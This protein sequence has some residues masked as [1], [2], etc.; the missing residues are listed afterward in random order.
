MNARDRIRQKTTEAAALSGKAMAIS[1]G[2]DSRSVELSVAEA[3][4][5]RDDDESCGFK[6]ALSL[7]CGSGSESS[8]TPIK[9]S[10]YDAGETICPCNE[11]GPAATMSTSTMAP[12][13]DGGPWATTACMYGE[14]PMT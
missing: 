4:A 3:A 7:G 13:S 10:F 11:F 8:C 14:R 12:M 1:A 9:P 2:L 6:S 5:R